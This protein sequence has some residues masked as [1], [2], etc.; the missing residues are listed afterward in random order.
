[1]DKYL[2]NFDQWGYCISIDSITDD[3]DLPE[4][5]RERQGLESEE[6]LETAFGHWDIMEGVREEIEEGARIRNCEIDM[7]DGMS[8]QCGHH[9]FSF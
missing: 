1:M 4:L 7:R 2:I 5:I 6:H 3:T 9:K 8:C